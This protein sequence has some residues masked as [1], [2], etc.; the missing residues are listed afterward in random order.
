L[1]DLPKGRYHAAL[2][3]LANSMLPAHMFIEKGSLGY[4]FGSVLARMTMGMEMGQIGFIKE[5]MNAS[6]SVFL[7]VLIGIQAD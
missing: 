3:V 1:T 7:G 2:S 4:M 6:G 5:P